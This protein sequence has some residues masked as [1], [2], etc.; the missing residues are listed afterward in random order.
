MASP[1]VTLVLPSTGVDAPASVLLNDG[2]PTGQKKAIMEE[3]G[4]AEGRRAHAE[5]YAQ[6]EPSDEKN[7][8]LA[9]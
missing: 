8:P 6:P 4:A 5:L 9:C 2:L 1:S 3:I 7:D